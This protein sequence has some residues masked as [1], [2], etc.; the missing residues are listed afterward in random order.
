MVSAGL[1]RLGQTVI[2]P[3]EAC[4]RSGNTC[5]LAEDAQGIQQRLA[6]QG[7]LVWGELGRVRVSGHLYNGSR[8]VERLLT[9]LA[10]QQR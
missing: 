6:S 8:D 3:T 10:A 9:V 2:T 1:R 7:V 5:F 4:A